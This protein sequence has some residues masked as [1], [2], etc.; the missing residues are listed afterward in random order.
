MNEIH[1]SVR[2]G[3]ERALPTIKGQ[4]SSQ[5]F[6][7]WVHPLEIMYVDEERLVFGTDD[8]F[9]LSILRKRYE[10]LIYDAVHMAFGRTYDIE[11]VDKLI[12]YT[13]PVPE[14]Q[15]PKE[16]PREATMLGGMN[17]L[18]PKYTFDA[19]VVG[20]SNRFAHSAA[21]AVAELPSHAY[22]PLFLYGGVGLGKTHLMH[23]IGHYITQTTPDARILY[24]TGEDFTNA[25]ITSL[26]KNNS[27]A[28]RDILRTV[29]VLMVDDIQFIAGKNSTQEEFFHTFNQLHTSGKQIIISSD[30]PPKEIP[31]LEERLRSRFEWGLIVDI[32]KPDFETRLAILQKKVRSEHMEIDDTMLS[33]IAERVLSNIRELEGS[34]NRVNAEVQLHGATITKELIENSL[35]AIM[36][37]RDVRNITPDAIIAT[38]CSFYQVELS[39][40][41]SEKRSRKI[42]QPRQVAMYLVREMTPLSTTRIGELFGGR[43]HSTVMHACDKVS[44]DIKEDPQFAQIIEN[45]K[46]AAYGA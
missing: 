44:R 41:R 8:K 19:F 1:P 5:G 34:L 24:C 2:A 43:D 23:A 33:I 21:L 15:A 28:L 30:R 25:L 42:A 46:A 11:F 10:S 38:V 35:N 13:P 4:M 39:D 6:A 31:T 14:P 12:P 32:Q 9:A 45:L 36:G 3:W 37:A 29:D 18:N 17:T 16:A 40:I 7:A 27:Q 20:S 26:R 22:N